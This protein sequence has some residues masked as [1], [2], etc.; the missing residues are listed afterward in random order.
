MGATGLFLYQHISESQHS[1]YLIE[2]T[3]WPIATTIFN[4]NFRLIKSPLK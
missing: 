3:D 2:E 1:P 4:R